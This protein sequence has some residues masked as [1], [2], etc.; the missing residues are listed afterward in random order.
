MNTKTKDK[1]EDI[2]LSG[3]LIDSMTEAELD[4]ALKKTDSEVTKVEKKQDNNDVYQDAYDT[5]KK[6]LKTLYIYYSATDHVYFEY[7]SD[8]DKWITYSVEPLRIKLRL[9]NV[10]VF[11]GFQAAMA[12]LGRIKDATTHT[13][14][15][16]PDYELNMLRTDHWLLPEPMNDGSGVADIIDLL[17]SALA[18]EDQKKKDHIE[19]CIFWKWYRPEDY[20]IPCMVFSGKG[21]AGKNTFV[22]TICKTIFGANQAEVLDESFTMGDFNGLLKG[23][24]I[25]LI[26]EFKATEKS[27]NSLKRLVGNEFIT[28]NNKGGKQVAMD[29]T[30][31]YI[32]ATN[33]KNGGVMPDG[34]AADRRWSIMKLGISSYE[35]IMKRKGMTFDEAKDWYQNEKWKLRDPEHVAAWLDYLMHKW[36]DMTQTPDPYHGD[37]YD[38]LNKLNITPIETVMQNIFGDGSDEI[39]NGGIIDE[40][41]P[42]Y[43]LS[44]TL[45][46]IY[47]GI[48]KSEFQN[49]KVLAKPKFIEQAHQWLEENKPEYERRKRISYYSSQKTKRLSA[50]GFCLIKLE[51]TQKDNSHLWPLG[52]F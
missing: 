20:E 19:Q 3:E 50:D 8:K 48:S 5:W 2:V 39:L 22:N 11:N 40:E 38:R 29:N 44:K 33:D 16:V 18:N 23:K 42:D 34:H 36:S 14:K 45:Y 52:T 25:I 27:A 31:M 9:L 35:L 37:D 1:T 30:A 43:I 26:D 13:H 7:K 46:N 47:K 4:N 12:D 32:I 51:G 24:T 10:N 17:L 28:I 21:A 6:K 15:P 41:A 49:Y